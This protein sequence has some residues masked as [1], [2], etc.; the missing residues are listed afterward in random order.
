MFR[1]KNKLKMMQAEK[2]QLERL[3]E[4]LLFI[5]KE[6]NDISP[7]INIE[8]TY[9]WE[10]N[11]ICNFVNLHVHKIYGKTFGG[12]G[13]IR[14]G[15]HSVLTDIFTNKVVY[16]KQSLDGICEKEFV[17]EDHTNNSYFAYFYPIYEIDHNLLAYVDKQVPLYILQ[18]LYFDINHI[19]MKAKVLRLIPGDN[20]KK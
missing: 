18:S 13:P 3:K 16:E 4:Q 5:Q 15:Y 10:V 8:N 7:R 14:E 2:Q 12:L 20:K 11:G 9:V 17:K 6:L 19:N 1:K